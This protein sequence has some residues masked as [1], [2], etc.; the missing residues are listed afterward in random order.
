MTTWFTADL[1]LGHRNIIEYCNRPFHDVDAM[2]DALVENWN[3]AVAPE[4][5]V[6]IVGDFALGKIAD[7]LPIA[8]TLHG[9]KILVAGN[10]DRCWA[11]HSG[12]DQLTGRV[13]RPRFDPQRGRRPHRSW[14]P[15]SDT[16]RS[17]GASARISAR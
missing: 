17:A 7:T 14:S 6:W 16:H 1:H 3:E 11:G 2:N 15:R 12:S 13:A 9:H 4:D 5:T 8:S 10:H